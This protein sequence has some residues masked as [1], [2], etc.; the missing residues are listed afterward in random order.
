MNGCNVAV[1]GG[2]PAGVLTAAH[3][4]KRGAKVTVYERRTAQQQNDPARGWSIALGEVATGA[5][6]A[7]GLSA[8][9]GVGGMCV[10]RV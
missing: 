5:I 4:A 1:I 2:G 6:E 3:F 8:D 7:A 9:F 10:P